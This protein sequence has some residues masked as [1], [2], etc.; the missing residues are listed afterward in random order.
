[1]SSAAQLKATLERHLGKDSD[2][3]V[4]AIRL[5]DL[6]TKIE[7]S[8]VTIGNRMFR[9]QPARSVLAFRELIATLPVGTNLLI[10]T[11]L[12]EQDLGDDVMVRLGKFR[13]LS[14][15]RWEAV[16]DK[17]A[18]TGIDP[19]LRASKELAEPLLRAEPSEGFLPAPLGILSAELA[20]V[21]LC[22]AYLGWP[23][24]PESEVEAYAAMLTNVPQLT[25]AMERHARE[26]FIA[27]FGPDLEH[28]WAH[29]ETQGSASAIAA[30]LVLDILE[31]GPTEA[32][33]TD[34]DLARARLE[35]ALGCRLGRTGR[36]AWAEAALRC[37]TQADQQLRETVE[38]LVLQW[39]SQI[40][41]ETLLHRSRSLPGAF[42][43]RMLVYCEQLE[44]RDAS[45]ANRAFA[46]LR[47]HRLASEQQSR[48]E[49][50]QDALRALRFLASPP[51]PPGSLRLLC[52]VYC[53]HHAYVD[54]LR[55][56]LS[57]QDDLAEVNQAHNGLLQDLDRERAAFDQAFLNSLHNAVDPGAELQPA[58][59]FL[60]RTLSPLSRA[61]R[62][63]L[64]VLDG[65]RWPDAT[66]FAESL[67]PLGWREL[68]L[69][70]HG[71]LLSPLPS[72]THL[73]RHSLL[74]GTLS[75]GHQS[76]ERKAFVAHPI[77]RE[78]CSSGYPPVIFHKASVRESIDDELIK[79]V[80]ED[81]RQVVAVVINAVDDLLGKGGQLEPLSDIQQ[82]RPLHEL[83]LQASKKD[84]TLVLVSDHGH[85]RDRT[86]KGWQVPGGVS[87]GQRWRRPAGKL[88]EGEIEI[89]GPRVIHPDTGLAEPLVFLT[90]EGDH[91]GTRAA[92]YHGGAH[93][94]EMLPPLMAFGRGSSPPEGFAWRP[95]REPLWWLEEGLASE[96]KDGTH[97]SLMFKGHKDGLA[98][99]LANSHFL[100]SRARSEE[101][102]LIEKIL[103]ALEGYDSMPLRRLAADC[104]VDAVTLQTFLPR[105]S[106][107][108][109]AGEGPMIYSDRSIVR[110][111][112]VAILQALRVEG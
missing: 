83:I 46:A 80:D 76:D 44:A 92:G 62:V 112:W 47:E 68:D 49:R 4:W 57:F 97:Q 37:Y 84:L 31:P 61:S 88:R 70:E 100:A 59:E 25:G 26:F 21:F 109:T 103:F 111:D 28:L 43:Q 1:M 99:R 77:L 5:D 20:W 36:L 18:A 27:K 67:R 48:I 52:R 54:R 7:H 55:Q 95:P 65:A 53:D 58:E 64:V 104:Q 42:E 50:A 101:Q 35:G 38:G 90:G 78:S 85:V 93:P 91:Y 60:E 13:L 39:I 12:S 2:A 16:L 9:V 15:A 105:L 22:L 11:D 87:S 33:T 45:E 40:A 14:A 66:R 6:P 3:R 24:L 98:A 81:R 75:P 63:L 94:V 8:T 107:I 56:T 29:L 79:R 23:R 51:K 73:A 82:I 86:G 17:F 96:A 108:L 74:S 72:V 71:T 34:L 106:A 30:G 41:A 102:A 10:V 69:D 110:V 89:A 19:R 32:Q